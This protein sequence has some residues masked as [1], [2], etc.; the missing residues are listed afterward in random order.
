MKNQA[1]DVIFRKFK[2]NNEIIA[3]FP[4]ETERNFGDCSSYMHMG[5]H[6]SANYDH[7]M[8]STKPVRPAEYRA[9]K[10]EL[11]NYGPKEAN[12]NLRVITRISWKR[13]RETYTKQ[14]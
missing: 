11:E 5:Q 9:L 4:Y 1:T 8:T 7:V 13:Y 6:G 3:L 14:N 2:S 10:T 12:Y